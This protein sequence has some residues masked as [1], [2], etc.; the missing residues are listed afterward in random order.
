MSKM[1]INYSVILRKL[2]TQTPLYQGIN[3]FFRRPFF[4]TEYK[5]NGSLL[6]VNQKI[7]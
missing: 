5:F 1:L 4:F 2:L 7:I 6:L 3:E